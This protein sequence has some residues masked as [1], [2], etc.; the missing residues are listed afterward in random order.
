MATSNYSLKTSRSV[1][2]PGES[3]AGAESVH[4]DS[5]LFVVSRASGKVAAS[6]LLFS[7]GGYPPRSL[8]GVTTFAVSI[9]I[10]L[11]AAPEFDKGILARTLIGPCGQVTGLP[12]RRQAYGPSPPCQIPALSSWREGGQARACLACAA[13]SLAGGMRDGRG[14]GGRVL[15]HQLP[16]PPGAAL[17][18]GLGRAGPRPQ[19]G[20]RSGS[21][22]AEEPVS[23]V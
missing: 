7:G 22:L 12:D 11:M 2:R 20:F 23:G 10:W 21:G 14:S 5:S 15:G 19:G 6:P 8:S 3:P 16:G 4:I 17:A 1:R 13:R 18:R 9:G